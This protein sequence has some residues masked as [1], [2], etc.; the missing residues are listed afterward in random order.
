MQ[1]SLGIECSKPPKNGWL[2]Y[3][4]FT[5]M[6][7]VWFL[8]HILPLPLL[9]NQLALSV[10][11]EIFCN[12]EGSDIH[13]EREKIKGQIAEW[14]R[15]WWLEFMP[16][17]WDSIIRGV[18]QSEIVNESI[19]GRRFIVWLPIVGSV[20]KF[21]IASRVRMKYR[22]LLSDNEKVT[23]TRLSSSSIKSTPKYNPH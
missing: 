1:S 16:I 5:V 2:E 3:G 9:S 19:R 13:W 23:R 4:Y 11:K 20:V 10:T 18:D 21:A 22:E 8:Y 15:K 17:Q 7:I 6:A 14:D 12:W